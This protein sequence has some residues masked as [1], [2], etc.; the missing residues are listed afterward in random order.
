MFLTLSPVA[1][2]A[3]RKI[4]LG[5]GLCDDRGAE[6]NGLVAEF[7]HKL[8][9]KDSSWETRVIFDCDEKKKTW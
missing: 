4:D 2:G 5:H 3:C 7:V 1:E 6:A 8:R 9:A